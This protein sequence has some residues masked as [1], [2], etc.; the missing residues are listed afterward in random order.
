MRKDQ[1]GAGFFGMLLMMTGL[2]LIVILGLKVVPAYMEYF[3]VQK[4]VSTVAKTGGSP[5]DIRRNFDKQAN[6]DYFDVINGQDLQITPNGPVGFAYTK[7]IPLFANVS[8]VIE[9][10][11]SSMSSGGGSSF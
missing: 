9:F 10:Q 11:G 5:A 7:H 8:L 2:V 1:R 3:T 6:V 4:A